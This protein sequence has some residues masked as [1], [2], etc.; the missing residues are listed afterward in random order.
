MTVIAATAIAVSVFVS[1]QVASELMD[2]ELR[3]T[4]ED[5]LRADSRVLAADV[6]R[7]GRAQVELPSSPGSGRLVR[8]ILPDGST[9]TPA[10]QPALPPVS[11]RAGRVAQ[12]A[13]RPRRRV[14]GPCQARDAHR[15]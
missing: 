12:G 10:G 4:A 3:D 11:E 15:P 14:E 1:F 8:V 2:R 7:A 9:R 6:E 13:G 5:Q